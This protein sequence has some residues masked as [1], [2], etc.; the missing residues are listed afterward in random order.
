MII[1]I[2]HLPK[3][4]NGIDMDQINSLFSEQQ[5]MSLNQDIPT[6]LYHQLYTLL[7]NNI[8][9]GTI[10]NGSQM[11]TEQQLAEAFNI[12]RITAKRA[13]DELSAENL[14]K[15]HRGKGTYVTYE[16]SPQPVR[17]PL[18]GMLQ[19]IESMA[20]RTDAKVIVLD[21]LNPP[22]EIREEFNMPAG[23]TALRVI[24]VRSR[25]GEPF[26]YYSSWTRGITKKIGRKTMES[27]P[28]L[29]I[30]RDHGLEI[31]HVTQTLTA[32]AATDDVAAALDTKPGAPLLCLIRRSFDPDEQLVDYLHVLYNPDRFQYQMDLKPEEQPKKKG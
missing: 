12:S 28:R 31:T 21:Q 26:G 13:L 32:M 23:E 24:R 2:D 10:P 9:N 15:R 20:R 27:K 11:P 7:H 8:L 17:A 1:P 19:E 14:V 18:I 6:P 3:T 5:R 22:A 30:F 4:E 25:D 16:Y 29:E